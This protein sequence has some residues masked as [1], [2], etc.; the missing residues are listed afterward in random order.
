MFTL[1]KD[2]KKGTLRILSNKEPKL[3][4]YE[5]IE[6]FESYDQAQQRREQL[7]AHGTVRLGDLVRRKNNGK[8]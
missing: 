2:R 6:E 8:Q 7:L 3:K 5:V 1:V 4:F